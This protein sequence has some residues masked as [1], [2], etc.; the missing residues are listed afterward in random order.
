MS[1]TVAMLNTIRNNASTEYQTRVPVATQTNITAVGDAI[2]TLTVTLNEFT[3]VLVEKIALT[4]FDQTLF[5]NKLA[6]FK[7]GMLPYGLTIEEIFVGM[8]TADSSYQ[9]ESTDLFARKK[10]D[11]IMVNYHKKNREDL[12][13]VTIADYQVRTAFRS[14]QG[15]QDLL[16]ELVQA[17]YVGCEFDEYVLMKELLAMYEDSY[18]D[19]GVPA[20]VDEATAKEFVKTTRKAINDLSFMSDKYNKN[21]VMRLNKPNELVLMVNKDVIA[22]VDVEVLAKAFNMGKTDF[23]ADI[24]VLDDF[25]SMTDTYGILVDRKWFMV[26]DTLRNLES[27]RN[28]KSMYTNYFLNVGQLLSLSKFKNAV[29]FTTV[30]K[31]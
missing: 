27:V 21:A 28:A 25:G 3:S 12:Y 20:I 24:V 10:P 13:S 29:R 1:Y 7:R 30:P 15:V 18:F 26:Y 31:V 4:I 22:E 2:A 23:Q 11:N 5:T 17:M 19:Y 8:L 9:K 16:A 14:D 6:P